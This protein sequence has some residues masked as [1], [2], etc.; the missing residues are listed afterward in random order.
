MDQHIE[1]FASEEQ[2][3]T[4]DGELCMASTPEE[5]SGKKRRKGK[6]GHARESACVTKSLWSGSKRPPWQLHT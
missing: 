2:D 6:A 5:G 1:P 4:S 3:S